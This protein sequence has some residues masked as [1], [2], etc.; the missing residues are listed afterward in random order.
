MKKILFSA[1]MMMA[2]LSLHAADADYQVVPLP[3]SITPGKGEA[4]V[5]DRSTAVNVAGTDGAMLRNAAFLKQYIREATGIVADGT[6]RRGAAITLKLNTKIENEEGYVITVKA[7]GITVEGKTPRGVFYGIQTLRKSLPLEQTERVD[8]PAVRIADYPRFSYRGTMLDCARHYFKV[9]FIKE[10]IDMLALHNINTFHW[11]LTEDQGWRV[12]I[13][14]YPRLAEVGSKRAQTVIGRMTGLYDDTPYGGC[15]TKEDMREVVKYAA[16]RYITVIPEIDMPGHMLGALAAYPELGCTGGPYQV[17]EKWGVFP[18]ILCAGNPKTYEFVYNVL[19]E[20]LEIFPSK[21][22]HLGGDEAPRDRW[23]TCP[24]CQA[25]IRRLGLKGANGFP[26]EAQ[27]QAYFMNRVA[28]HLAEKGRNIIGWDEI[29]EGDADKGTTVMSWRGVAGGQ[30]AARRG[31]DA[32][33][34]PTSYYYLD[35]YQTKNDALTLIGG[36]LPVET[37]Y[38]YNP[39]PD[40]AAPELKQHIKGVQANLW[41]EYIFGR[42][43]AFYQLLPRTA[44]M[45]ET[46]WTE[47]ARK[48]FSSFKKREARLNLLYRHFGWKACQELFKE[49]KPQ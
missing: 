19:D 46:G 4:F 39:V 18:D 24:R 29:L 8:F 3:Q 13:D 30:E 40:D 32:V 5:L 35:Y 38:G 11:H 31:L 9:S 21:Y 14:R 10:F 36:L 45:A 17:A 48:D 6:D 15:Y 22:I 37:T 20:L 2:G 47:N 28:K 27:L 25:E 7:K 26:A 12:Q 23:K 44:A 33:M 16:D 34:S 41:T 1:A 43:L 42:D 49:E